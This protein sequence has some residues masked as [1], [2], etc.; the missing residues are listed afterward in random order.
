M[1]YRP[2]TRRY[3][4]VSGRD[5][6]RRVWTLLELAH[7]W[8]GVIRSSRATRTLFLTHILTLTMILTLQY[9]YPYP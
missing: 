8:E 2:L 7:L 4:R 5:E 6:S 3:T 9:P 1:L